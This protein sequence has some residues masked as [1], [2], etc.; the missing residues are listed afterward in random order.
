M[1]NHDCMMYRGFEFLIKD[2]PCLR[3]LV[4]ITCTYDDICDDYSNFMESIYHD[5]DLEGKI[6]EY[7]KTFSPYHEQDPMYRR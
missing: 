2:C 4:K 5:K 3:C 7:E 1:V 6:E